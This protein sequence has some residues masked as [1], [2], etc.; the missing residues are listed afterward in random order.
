MIDPKSRHVDELKRRYEDITIEPNADGSM[1]ITIPNFPLPP[2]WNRE[3]TVIRFLVPV[4]FPIARP[5]CFW[6]DADLRLSSGGQPMNTALQEPWARKGQF[7]WFSWHPSYWD[8]QKDSLLNFVG[9][10]AKRLGEAR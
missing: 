4:G 8:P 7:L 3:S 10:I 5:D 6:A 2:G 9:I 1:I